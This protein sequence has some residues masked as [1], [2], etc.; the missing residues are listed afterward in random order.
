MV[1]KGLHPQLLPLLILITPPHL[2]WG[3]GGTILGTDL[4]LSISSLI[5]VCVQIFL[6]LGQFR[7][8]GLLSPPG[9][10]SGNFLVARKLCSAGWSHSDD[11]SL[12]ALRQT[13]KGVWPTW[14]SRPEGKAEVLSR[15]FWRFLGQGRIA[16]EVKGL[17]SSPP[18]PLHFVALVQHQSLPGHQN[19]WL[20]GADAILTV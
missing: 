18:L 3:L 19:P 9:G 5:K 14:H 11:E 4:P 20:W 16:W 13:R 2:C 6:N 12:L 7:E 10:L 1:S 15:S 17:S 8:M